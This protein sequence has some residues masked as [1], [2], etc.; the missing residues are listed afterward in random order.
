MMS[1]Q[2]LELVVHEFELANKLTSILT[3]PSPNPTAYPAQG[4]TDISTYAA[5]K[6]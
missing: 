4:H 6:I 2:N 3:N 1:E 5:P